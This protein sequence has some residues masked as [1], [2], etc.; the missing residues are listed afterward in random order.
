MPR[1]RRRR[2]VGADLRADLRPPHPHRRVTGTA[3]VEGERAAD[4]T[5]DL[6]EVASEAIRAAR[7]SI[8]FLCS[9]NNP[10][11]TVDDE[12]TGRAPCSTPSSR[13]TGCWSSTRP[14]ASSR[15]GRRCRLVDEERSLVVT[16]TYSKTWSAAALRLGYLIGPTWVVDELEKVVLPYHLDAF[17]Q[18]A[19]TLALDYGDEMEAR[20][21][22]LVEERGRVAEAPGRRSRSSCGRRARTSSCSGPTGRDGAAVWQD[23][24]DRSVL[25]RNCSSWPRPRRLPAGHPRHR[26]PR[27]TRSSPP[28]RRCSPDAERTGCGLGDACGILGA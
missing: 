15:R 6:D 28:S 8:T 12:P 2:A 26:R 21:A 7:P 1:L 4:F 19:G 18:L 5:L 16:R 22:R 17:K 9:P 14:T 24:V 11:G 3:V 20:V 23:L 10:T 13:S 27:T 25:V